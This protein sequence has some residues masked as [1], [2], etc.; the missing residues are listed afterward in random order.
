M[1]ARVSL[2]RFVVEVSLRTRYLAEFH[3]FRCGL[4]ILHL[5]LLSLGGF[6]IS[7]HTRLRTE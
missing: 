5:R 3:T 7:G 4:Q 6:S 1:F 2:V